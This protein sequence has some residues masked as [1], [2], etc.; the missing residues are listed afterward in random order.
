MNISSNRAWFRTGYV[1]VVLVSMLVL[2]GCGGSK[3]GGTVSGK[4]SYPSADQLVKGGTIN[5]HPSK[6][7]GQPIMIS[8]KPDGTFS[9]GGVA[10]GEY[11]VTVETESIKG[12]SAGSNPYA[13]QMGNMKPPPGAESKMPK[14][15]TSN[16]PSYV[17]IPAK[18][19]NPQTS[20][21]KWTIEKGNQVKD[22]PLT[23]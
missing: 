12:M 2:A 19:G 11:T 1:G 7:G 23:N 18:Y 22:L 16:M 17:K 3:K 15:D 4:V 20:G 10:A 8:I 13:A 5:L 14:M 9:Q 21:L 6:E